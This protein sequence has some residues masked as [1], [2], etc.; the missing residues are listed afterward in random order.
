MEVELRARVAR[1]LVGGGVVMITAGACVAEVGIS[2]GDVAD[3]VVV[4]LLSLTAGV[5]LMLVGASMW[6][7]GSRGAAPGD[8]LEPSVHSFEAE[9]IDVDLVV[10]DP[11]LEL[12]VIVVPPR[13]APGFDHEAFPTSMFGAP[14]EVVPP[15]TEQWVVRDARA[16][17]FGLRTETGVA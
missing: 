14:T 3:G 9:W 2:A 5:P 6:S 8:A 17:L 12:D 1:L 4:A 13:A 10:T 7:R 11:S 15:S 16:A